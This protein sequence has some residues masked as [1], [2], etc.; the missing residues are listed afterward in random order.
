MSW[1]TLAEARTGANTSAS[2]NAAAKLIA[3][4]LE[5]LKAGY[6]VSHDHPTETV[7]SRDGISLVQ[8]MDISVKEYRGLA[9]DLAEFLA[10][11][12]QENNTRKWKMY[13]ITS[14]GEMYESET[15]YGGPA[16]SAK[17]YL[18]YWL[19]G[20]GQT[21]SVST[22]FYP[23]TDG[24]MVEAHAERANSADGWMVRAIATSYTVP[25]PGYHS[26]NRTVN[27]AFIPCPPTE[28]KNGVVVSQS[29][30]KTYVSND[31]TNSVYQNVTTVVR[32]Y[33]CLTQAEANTKVT[34]EAASNSKTYD[35]RVLVSWGTLGSYY[36]NMQVRGGGDDGQTAATDK[37][38]TSRPQGD[39]LY[40]VS[41]NEV[42]YQVT[43]SYG[44]GML[45]KFLI[46][47]KVL[48][49]PASWLNAVANIL[50]GLA[51]V[52]GTVSAKLEGEG[53]GSN[54][55]L[56][57]VPSAAAREMRSSLAADFICKGDAALLGDGLKWGER[58][59]TIDTEWLDR[60]IVQNLKG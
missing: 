43:F 32:E 24:L 58:G 16:S 55:K 10:Q 34:S 54:I 20:A 14:N 6:E 59:L 18:Y 49:V 26:N 12:L 51:S 42:T 44:A 31:G 19:G 60:Q 35:V 9:K 56:D 36:K 46:K 40:T 53:E 52:K 39:G 23:P 2:T 11:Y 48:F 38:A 33:R 5:G 7:F 47:R 50:N 45:S 1:I 37:V 22:S 4:W 29:K 57:I 27:K 30:Q 41:V 8:E 3:T 21:K 17:A 28:A 25:D 15:T 13:G